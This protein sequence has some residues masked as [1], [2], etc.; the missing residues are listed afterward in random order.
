MKQVFPLQR[1]M[2]ALEPPEGGNLEV[3]YAELWRNGMRALFRAAA[4]TGLL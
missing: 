2:W 3:N 4:S 1:S